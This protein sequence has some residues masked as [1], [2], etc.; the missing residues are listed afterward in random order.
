M[1]QQR[2]EI[3]YCVTKA[4]RDMTP[5][6]FVDTVNLRSTDFR[7]T[8]SDLSTDSFYLKRKNFTQQKI[9]SFV[10]PGLSR[11]PLTGAGV[12]YRITHLKDLHRRR[13]PF[14]TSS[15]V[16]NWE[17]ILNC[18]S[19][20]PSPSV[21]NSKTGHV[22]LTRDPFKNKRLRRSLQ[23]NK[24]KVVWNIT[25]RRLGKSLTLRISVVPPSSASISPRRDKWICCNACRRNDV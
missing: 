9:K 8:F 25:P 24:T 19:Q 6:S 1:N 2:I 21:H 16:V 15:T 17:A 13:C 14:P 22:T 20:R 10:K 3:T 18:R 23:K 12:L 4:L 5:C 11:M 7:L